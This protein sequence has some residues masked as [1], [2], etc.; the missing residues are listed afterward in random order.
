MSNEKTGDTADREAAARGRK[1]LEENPELAQHVRELA[2]ECA[3]L[4]EF[5]EAFGYGNSCNRCGRKGLDDNEYT[6]CELVVSDDDPAGVLVCHECL[7]Y[8]DAD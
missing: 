4:E 2:P 1:I 7:G 5:V 8:Q 6:D 3:N